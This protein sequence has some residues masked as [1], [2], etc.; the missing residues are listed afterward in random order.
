MED[1]IRHK[2]TLT[3]S[4]FDEAKTLDRMARALKKRIDVHFKIDTGMGRLGCWH[5][6]AREELTS[7]RSLPGLAVKGLYTHFCLCR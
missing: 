4:S 2:L 3:L 1:A 6:R 5:L 7:I